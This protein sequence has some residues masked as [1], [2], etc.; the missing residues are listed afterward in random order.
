[1][2][3]IYESWDEEGSTNSL[4]APKKPE[5]QQEHADF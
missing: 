1:M 2:D 5:I 3:I 4:P